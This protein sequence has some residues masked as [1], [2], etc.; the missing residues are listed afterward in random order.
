MQVKECYNV[1]EKDEKANKDDEE[2]LLAYA[3]SGNYPIIEDLLCARDY[4]AFLGV[5]VD[6]L[7]TG[8]ASFKR[9]QEGVE[10]TSGRPTQSKTRSTEVHHMQFFM[11]H[12]AS[13]ALMRYKTSAQSTKF[14]PEGADGRGSV[15]ISIFKEGA[16]LPK[17]DDE[18]P[19]AAFTYPWKNMEEVKTT[20][21]SMQENYPDHMN[22]GQ[23]EE[24]EQWFEE[25]PTSPA[26]VALADQPLFH[27]QP[28]S[29]LAADLPPQRDLRTADRSIMDPP[30]RPM[31]QPVTHAGYTPAERRA[32]VGCLLEGV[33]LSCTVIIDMCTSSVVTISEVLVWLNISMTRLQFGSLCEAV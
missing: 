1:E 25:A 23:H 6:P 9:L 5:L 11:P 33:F 22:V 2:R 7:I 14:Y 20:I 16:V 31:L 8:F 32:A 4:D 26:D 24:W 3:I 30:N 21:L 10:L 15:G 28:S 12:G 18:P 29:H 17:L 19:L 13:V 27:L